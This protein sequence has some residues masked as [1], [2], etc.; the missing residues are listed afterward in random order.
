[1]LV[2]DDVVSDLYGGVVANCLEFTGYEVARFVFASGEPSKNINTYTELL[3]AL[4][5]ANLTR[6]DVIV[7][8]GGG[9]VGDIAGFAAA[10]YLRGIHF[11]QI[12]TTLLAMVDSS[13]GGKTA[14]NLSGGAGG[15]SSGGKNQVGA[16]Y[17]PDTV[18]CDYDTLRT[19][20]GE[21]FADGCAEIIKHA[22]ISSRELFELLNSSASVL[23]EQEFAEEIIARN[24]EIKRDAVIRDER[25]VGIRQI[26][27]FGHTLGHGIEKHSDYKI[28]HGSAV[29]IGM[30]LESRGEHRKEIIALLKR[31]GLPTT[32][33]ITKEQLLD[34]AF[35]DKK[36]TGDKITVVELKQIGECCTKIISME[37][38]NEYYDFPLCITGNG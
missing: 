28:S 5:A 17:Q 24:I 38:L 23:T 31:Y 34:A 37:E 6:G 2:T 13:V 8:L 3:H 27:N 10:T 4:C 19:L 15:A 18:L 32:T 20:P 16:F 26:L 1:M 9:V 30:V 21:V 11:V 35:S 25:D 33:S 12:P 14:I 22:V 36:R 29:A 7:A